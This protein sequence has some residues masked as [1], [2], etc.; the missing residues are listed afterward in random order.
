MKTKIKHLIALMIALFAILVNTGC[1]RGTYSDGVL[2][3]ENNDSEETSGSDE[4]NS[5]TQK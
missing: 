1:E 2:S 5:S 3:E 4:T